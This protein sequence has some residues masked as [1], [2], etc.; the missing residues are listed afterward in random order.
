LNTDCNKPVRCLVYGFSLRETVPFS[1]LILYKLPKT[2]L[3]SQISNSIFL[4]DPKIKKLK[5]KILL[6][7]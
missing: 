7:W 4:D 5:G 6:F 3:N 2:S 1:S